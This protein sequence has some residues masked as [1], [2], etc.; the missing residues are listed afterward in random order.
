MRRRAH[1]SQILPLDQEIDRTF[2]KHRKNLEQLS[3]GSEPSSPVL[4]TASEVESDMSEAN[5]Q[6]FRDFENSGSY[7]L[8]GGILLPI[9]ISN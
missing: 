7:V 6:L 2:G 5:S 9:T 4:S 1:G 8:Q 3:L